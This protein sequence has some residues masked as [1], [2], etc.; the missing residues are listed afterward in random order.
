MKLVSV[1]VKRGSGPGSVLVSD[2]DVLGLQGTDQEL[3]FGHGVVQ[4]PEPDGGVAG[5][6]RR[7]L[8]RLYDDDLRTAGVPWGREEA[9][10]R[11]Q[12]EFSVHGHIMR[13]GRVNPFSDR[14]TVLGTGVVEFLTLDVDRNAWEEVIPAAVVEVQMGIYDDVYAIEIECM[15]VERMRLRVEGGGCG[16]DLGEAA[17]NENRSLGM[18]DEVHIDGHRIALGGQIADKKGRDFD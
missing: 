5:D 15:L 6:D 10:S 14:V 2:P 16:M 8:P 9:D 1:F 4:F 18:F 11:K 12:F 3:P 13:A 7:P 17:V